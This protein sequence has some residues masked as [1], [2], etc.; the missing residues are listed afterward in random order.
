[1]IFSAGKCP[2]KHDAAA[3]ETQLKADGFVACACEY[4]EGA[5]KKESAEESGNRHC[6]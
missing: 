4:Q 1:M 5:C 2:F 3:V 6:Y